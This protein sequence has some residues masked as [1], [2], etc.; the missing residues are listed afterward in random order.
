M[1]ASTKFSK[2]LKPA[3]GWEQMPVTVAAGREV[4]NAG[5][6]NAYAKH[7]PLATALQQAV[8]RRPSAARPQ[9]PQARPRSP[10]ASA[11]ADPELPDPRDG[12]GQETT[13][14]PVPYLAVR[15]RTS[16][17]PAGVP[18]I[19]PWP[20]AGPIGPTSYREWMP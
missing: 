8:A 3:D 15:G 5:S 9:D 19:W 12:A 20:V 7:E 11:T 4:Q 14:D 10:A 13:G 6:P 1:Y 2:A 18:A 16:A 17:I